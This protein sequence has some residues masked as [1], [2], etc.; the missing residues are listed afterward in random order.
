MT[1]RV[2]KSEQAKEVAA[3]STNRVATSDVEVG[4]TSRGLSVRVKLG[5]TLLAVVAT[6]AACGGSDD[7]AGG[8]TAPQP[9][10]VAITIQDFDFGDPATASVGDTVTVTNNDGVPH[11]WTSTDGAFDSGSLA[12][13]D[14]FSF[15]FD[16]AGEYS[17]FCAIH[18]AMTGTITVTS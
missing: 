9:A 13:G 15:T 11:T 14:E 10:Q 12:E 2:H 1:G 7:D 8:G 16:E 17:F 18:P 5:V 6:L 3:S 4:M